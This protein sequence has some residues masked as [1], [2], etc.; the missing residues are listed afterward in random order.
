MII[1]KKQNLS[2]CLLT[3]LF[4]VVV[5]VS[6]AQEIITGII[7]DKKSKEPLPYGTI[8]IKN[9]TNGA[10]TNE[11]GTFKVLTKPDDTLIISYISFE[12]IEIPAYYFTK[13]NTYY[14][15]PIE[16]DLPT[17]EITANVDFMLDLLVS[18][19]KKM[20]K[21][22]SFE[23]KSY[24]TLKSGFT[25]TPLELLEC[26][27]NVE[28]NATGFDKLK[29]KNGRIG[30]SPMHDSW[31]VSLSST[32]IL[33]NYNILNRKYN[34]FPANPLHFTKKNIK[35]NYAYQVLVSAK[36]FLSI[37]FI[38]KNKNTHLFTTII[39]IDKGTEQIIEV[40]LL[41]KDLKQHPF[42]AIN[43]K[44]NLS[45]LNLKLTYTYDI[46]PVNTLSKVSFNY[47]FNYFKNSKESLI[48]TDGVFLFYDINKPFDL[49]YYSTP[50]NLDNDY[51][52]IIGL[53][54]NPIFWN[55]NQTILPSEE[56][57]FFK[58]F[59]NDNG[60]LLNFDELKDNNP[61]LQTRVIPWSEKRI[62]QYMLGDA[63]STKLTPDL[64]D[65]FSLNSIS[66]GFNLDAQIYLDRDKVGGKTHYTSQT[67]VNTDKSYYY[68]D[69][70]KNTTCFINLYFD[71][72]EMT[73][74][75]M[76]KKL[77][78]KEWSKTQVDS[79]F[80][81]TTSTL[82]RNLN[83]YLNKVRRG[84]NETYLWNLIDSVKQ[85]LKIDNAVLIE[86]DDIR[87]QLDRYAQTNVDYL[88][89][90]NYG[91]ALLKLENYREAKEILLKCVELGDDHPWLFY[92]L[93]LACYKL[94]EKQNACLYFSKSSA[95]GETIEPEFMNLCE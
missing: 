74:R 29:L 35:E 71:Q 4:F 1:D 6:F 59:F 43:K 91:S 22:N 24:F 61:L 38:P 92:N 90:Y 23:S 52:K 70:N 53:P 48:E 63:Y 9:S 84:E 40:S 64:A 25:D 73:R 13:N 44:D 93:G 69:V 27:Y 67:M 68:M 80:Y 79:I 20:R 54:Y 89:Y 85:S 5:Q 32:E 57:T 34:E 12:R 26:Y 75:A 49:P 10:I 46:S 18:T 17:V 94:D 86:D 47:S 2:T 16:N 8:L 39:T 28:L 77:Q 42:K 37:E 45:K 62:F 33:S 36:D 72:I 11:D 30:L 21:M 78:Q 76:I 19:R 14:L 82:K 3:L 58:N 95:L 66:N 83:S 15:T 81:V 7:L 88:D 31:F 55:A 41:K 65:L 51:Q 50:E 56:Y 60:I 87:L